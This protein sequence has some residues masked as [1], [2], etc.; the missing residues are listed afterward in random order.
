MPKSMF[1]RFPVT[2]DNLEPRGESEALSASPPGCQVQLLAVT[3]EPRFKEALWCEESRVGIAKQPE[4]AAMA[5]DP[6][7]TA[8]RTRPTANPRFIFRFTT[9]LCILDLAYYSILV[10]L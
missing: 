6:T 1:L 3:D 4:L 2:T 9:T 5:G 10:R 7:T 8:L